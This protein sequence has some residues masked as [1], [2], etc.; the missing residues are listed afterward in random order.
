MFF[1]LRIPL[2]RLLAVEVSVDTVL[3]EEVPVR[4]F[5]LCK[6][7]AVK[8]PVEEV[9]V[10]EV[11]TVEVLAKIQFQTKT[12]ANKMI[13]PFFKKNNIETFCKKREKTQ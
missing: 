10:V 6:V 8:A 5:P 1:L 9:R 7:L 12:E 3:A 13:S 2:K 11:P 4:K